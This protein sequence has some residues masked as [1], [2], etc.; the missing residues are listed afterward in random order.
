MARVLL[1]LRGSNV[2]TG[3]ER[4]PG[5]AQYF[6]LTHVRRGGEPINLRHAARS[7]VGRACYM[8]SLVPRL[9]HVLPFGDCTIS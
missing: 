5:D 2:P 8:H 7:P 4:G 6:D 3:E 1:G 9:F